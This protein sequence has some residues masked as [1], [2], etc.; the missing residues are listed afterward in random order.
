MAGRAFGEMTRL[1]SSS[2]ALWQGIFSSNADFVGEAIGRLRVCLEQ[3]D[4]DRADPTA[5]ARTFARA[6]A[7][8]E[9][10]RKASS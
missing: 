5:L 1:A 8:R 6:A 2:P 10:F 4:K 7:F 9:V 3:L